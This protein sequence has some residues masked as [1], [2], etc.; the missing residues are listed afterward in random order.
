MFEVKKL[1]LE[2]IEENKERV[3]EI[4]DKIWEYAELGL[5]EYKS[6]IPPGA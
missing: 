3:I 6:P 5:I 4:C 2:W 1:A